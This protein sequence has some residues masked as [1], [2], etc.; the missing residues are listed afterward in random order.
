[1]QDYFIDHIGEMTPLDETLR[2][3]AVLQPIRRTPLAKS[4]M[5]K[6]P[7]ESAP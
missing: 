2:A 7:E 6:I 4:A 5:Q 3:G 1:V